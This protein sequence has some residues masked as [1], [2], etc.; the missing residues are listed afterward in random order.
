MPILYLYKIN[1]IIIK[2]HFYTPNLGVNFLRHWVVLSGGRF[3]YK[4]FLLSKRSCPLL[5]DEFIRGPTDRASMSGA[6]SDTI[7]HFQN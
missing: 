1:I 4:G 3:E 5:F 7:L 6:S 2:T